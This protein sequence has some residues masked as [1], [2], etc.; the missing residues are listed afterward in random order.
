MD[1]QQ[2]QLQLANDLWAGGIRCVVAYVP[3]KDPRE[4]CDQENLSMLVHIKPNVAETHSVKAMDLVEKEVGGQRPTLTSAALPIPR[5][6]PL[7][8]PPPPPAAACAGCDEA[9]L[10]V[11]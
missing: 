5:P 3:A 1:L 4:F 7:S 8:P 2:V 9:L 11:D 6:S 10:R